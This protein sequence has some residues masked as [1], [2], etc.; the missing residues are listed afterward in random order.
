MEGDGIMKWAREDDERAAYPPY[1]DVIENLRDE[2]EAATTGPEIE[3]TGISYAVLGVFCT[4]KDAIKGQ[5]EL[6]VFP[7]DCGFADNDLCYVESL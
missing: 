4:I 5:G 6:T 7:D 2:W 1:F 3:E